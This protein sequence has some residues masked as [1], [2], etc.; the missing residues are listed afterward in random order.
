MRLILLLLCLLAIASPVSS[1]GK[2]RV[3]VLLEAR[4]APAYAMLAREFSSETGIPTEL[5]SRTDADFKEELPRWLEGSANAPDVFYW[6]ASQRL[7]ALVKQGKI[8]PITHL[9]RENNLDRDFGHARSAVEYQ[10]DQYGIPF[11]YYS[12]GIYYRKSLLKTYGGPPKNW[13]D[14]VQICT[15][16]KQ[17][18]ITPIAIGTENA[19]PAAAWFDYLNLRIN[20]LPFHQQLLAGEVSFLD[21]RVRAVFTEWEK[22]VRSGFFTQN[23]AQYD[24]SE[25]L[26]LLYRN[27]SAF[28]LIGAFVSSK[29][30]EEIK[31]DFDFMS[32]PALSQTQR[33]E[34]AP[35]DIF[36]MSAQSSHKTMAE[37]FLKYIS[38]PDVQSRHNGLLG[39]LPPN[40]S[41]EVGEDLFIQKGFEMLR[42]AAGVAQYFDRDTLPEFEKPAVRI[43]ARFLETGDV[44]TA[45]QQLESVRVKV[46]GKS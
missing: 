3:A 34:E 38:R 28:M 27:K 25:V 7:F 15:L 31:A 20:G 19:W 12:W 39:Y 18:G 41:S 30:S 13:E 32:F 8:E 26:P 40:R 37:A 36:M 9:W 42:S 43:L 24:W 5:V 35:M 14:F 17:K 22:L 16:M 6:Q 2:L 21:E 23:S 45:L 29:I 46:F 10:G 11:S 4:Q 1:A 33:Y 44:D